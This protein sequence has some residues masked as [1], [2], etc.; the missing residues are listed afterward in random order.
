MEIIEFVLYGI[1]IFMAITW[2]VGIRTYTKR[3]T[4]PAMS[5]VNTT[6]LFIVSLITIPILEIS[7]FHF[8]WI[9]PVAIFIGFLSISP[10]FSIL[11]ILGNILF[12]IVCLGL[13][14]EE[15]NRAE[16][17]I[18]R[19]VELVHKEGLTVEEAK[20]RIDEE[21]TLKEIAE[22]KQYKWILPRARTAI[23]LYL[24]IS[25]MGFVWLMNNAGNSNMVGISDTDFSIGVS[26]GFA[27]IVMLLLVS[28]CM[29]TERGDWNIFIR[30]I[31][32]PAMF[33]V[34]SI[35][36]P[37]MI[38]PVFILFWGL[39]I[40]INYLVDLIGSIISGLLII[41][42]SMRRSKLFRE[43]KIHIDEL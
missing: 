38:F 1:A 12:N 26:F 18:R 15:I 25:F 27:T 11:S 5:T 37:L 4:R 19:G 16:E 2:M 33:F 30:I 42:F 22:K 34:N 13:N 23:L 3:G 6:A 24:A 7:A 43:E 32:V 40:E 28:I 14:F 29:A 17:R 9:Y 41:V 31:F 39:Q 35:L 20:T 21:D 8:L 10:P 36:T